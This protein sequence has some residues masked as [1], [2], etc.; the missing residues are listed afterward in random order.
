MHRILVYLLV[1]VT[2]SQGASWAQSDAL[3]TGFISG[4][5]TDRKTD[6]TMPF[7]AVRIVELELHVITG[8]NGYY[9]FKGIPPGRYTVAVDWVGYESYS[10]DNVRVRSGEITHEDIALKFARLPPLPKH[11]RVPH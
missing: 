6:E 11:V 5:V 8:E 9:A 10:N 3:S 7:A 1:A 4:T 2:A